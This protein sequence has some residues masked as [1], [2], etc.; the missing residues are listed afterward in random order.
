MEIRRRSLGEEDPSVAQG[1]LLLAEAHRELGHALH[2]P[3]ETRRALPLAQR[4]LAIVEHAEGADHPHAAFALVEIGMDYVNLGLHAEAEPYLRRAL[5]LRRRELA[6]DH[7]S[8]AKA[9]LV[10]SECLLGLG[11]WDE[12]DALLREASAPLSAQFP[13]DDYRVLW[14]RDLQVQLARVRR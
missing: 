5:D 12:A 11:R 3:A 2:E 9:K 13:P 4:S 10:L 14:A 6:A 7:P 1:L 8:L